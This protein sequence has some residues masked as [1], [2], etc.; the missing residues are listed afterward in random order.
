[1]VTETI[2][3]QR[4][5]QFGKKNNSRKQLLVGTNLPSVP[6]WYTSKCLLSSQ[7]EPIQL[8]ILAKGQEV[9]IA[10][11]LLICHLTIEPRL[12]TK[13]CCSLLFTL[14]T[15]E[16]SPPD[17]SWPVP[18]LPS[19][20]S[21]AEVSP[22]RSSRS[23]SGGKWTRNGSQRLSEG[24]LQ[25]SRG[26][27]SSGR[28]HVSYAVLCETRNPLLHCQKCL[29]RCSLSPIQIFKADLQTERNVHCSGN[30]LLGFEWPQS[31]AKD[32]F[33]LFLIIL[34]FWRVLWAKYLSVPL[35]HPHC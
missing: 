7:W 12:L 11:T 21:Q 4:Y 2:S 15:E 19:C 5:A 14:E 32:A 1:M 6:P 23:Q 25:R 26:W 24:R 30:D 35:P 13:C 31:F 22:S 20:G 18:L 16:M 28:K 8:Y 3:M 33:Q 9:A 34:I 17:W 10:I 27:K 29:D